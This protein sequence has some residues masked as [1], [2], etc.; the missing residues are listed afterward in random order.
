MRSTI[1]HPRAVAVALCCA[2]LGVASAAPGHAQNRAFKVV[3]N[4]QNP[5]DELPKEEVSRLF[6]KKLRKWPG[7]DEQVMPADLE[8]DSPI[9]EAFSLEVLGRKPIQVHRFWQRQLFA[10]RDAPPPIFSSDAQVLDFVR[11]NPGAIGYVASD[12]SLGDGVK[13]LAIKEFQIV[14]NTRNPTSVLA[15]REV[16]DIYLKKIT[17]W[18]GWQEP[19]VPVDNLSLF[20]F[21][22]FEI[23]GRKSRLLDELWLR[24][25]YRYNLDPPP[26]LRSNEEVLDYVRTTPGAIGYVSR[27]AVLGTGVKLVTVE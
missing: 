7:W 25:Q 22:S 14:V 9:R 13:E 5:T 2:L 12:T 26:R 6:L 24:K 16:A 19:I 10:G 11:R 1:F 3:V 8:V 21:F 27:D 20:T 4:G 18:E 23:F 17:V 15:K